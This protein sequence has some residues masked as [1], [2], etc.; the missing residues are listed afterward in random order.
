MENIWKEPMTRAGRARM[1]EAVGR[2]YGDTD[3]FIFGHSILGEPLWCVRRGSGTPVMLYVGAH[4]G[5][6]HLTGNLLYAFLSGR[7]TPRGT[8]YVIPCLNPDGVSLA[9]E[10]AAA[11]G[12]LTARQ[13]RMN[14]GDDFR[15]WQANARGVDLNHNY[16]AGFEAYRAVQVAHGIEGGGPTRYAGEYP[17]SEPETAALIGLIATVAPSAV[18]TLHT[19]GREIFWGRDP[20]RRT[21]IWGHLL[22]RRVGYAIGSPTGAA[23]YGGLTDTL[24]EAGIPALT[25]ECGWGQN[26]LP[27]GSLPAL[28]EEV[29]PLLTAAAECLEYV[30]KL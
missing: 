30:N 25:V 1:R 22:A 26:P 23:A 4:H 27:A 16:P 21:R 18:L 14:G 3:Q 20:A 2:A 11:G 10:G 7:D 13:R 6:E 5:M 8:Y 17:L 28:C 24:A 9:L 15:R 29:S 12:I 19:Q